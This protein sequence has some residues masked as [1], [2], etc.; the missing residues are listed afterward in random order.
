MHI[1]SLTPDEA[2]T[3]IQIAGLV[4]RRV[5]AEL[6][7]GSPYRRAMLWWGTAIQHYAGAIVD[8]DRGQMGAPP[9]VLEYIAMAT[10]TDELVV[11]AGEVAG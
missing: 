4:R 9:V 1:H 8:G 3:A 5:E 7:K 11:S 2:V 10:T 6:P